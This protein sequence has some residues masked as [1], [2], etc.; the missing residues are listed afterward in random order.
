MEWQDKFVLG[1]VGL[2]DTF[3]YIF[4]CIR[5]PK[6]CSGWDLGMKIVQARGFQCQSTAHAETALEPGNAKPVSICEVLHH[7][8]QGIASQ[9]LPV[10][11]WD[12]AG[13]LFSTN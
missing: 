12:F 4:S 10:L 8:L 13:K 11:G 5:S 6:P 2:P 7:K 3:L 9:T 1:S